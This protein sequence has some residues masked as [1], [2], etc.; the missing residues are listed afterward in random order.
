MPFDEVSVNA[1]YLPRCGALT[2]LSLIE[3]SRTCS[4]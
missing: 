1:A 2:V 3:K 4:S